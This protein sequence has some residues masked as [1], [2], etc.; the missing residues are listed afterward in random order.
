MQYG[1][2]TA[3]GRLLRIA[4][5]HTPLYTRVHARALVYDHICA[6]TSCVVV[7]YGCGCAK[8]QAPGVGLH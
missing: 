1:S 5:L 4:P 8:N 6:R 2:G 3:P 7:L